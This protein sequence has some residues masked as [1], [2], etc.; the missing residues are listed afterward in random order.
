MIQKAL[1]DNDAATTDLRKALAIN[2]HFSILWSPVAAR[3]LAKLGRAAREEKEI[4]V[5][6]PLSRLVCV[7][8]DF[9]AAELAELLPLLASELNVKM[10]EFADS[11]SAL[12]TLVGKASFRSL[13]KQFG[14]RTPEA[15]KAVEALTS[16]QLLAFERG[17]TVSVTVDGEEY[18]LLPEDVTIVRHAAGSLLVRE[19]NG[20]FAAID[21]TI[22]P[23]LRREGA[24]R[25]LVSKIQQMRK[26]ARFAVSD[27]VRV[28]LEGGAELAAV[29]HEYGT[30]IAGEVL[31]NEITVAGVL[32]ETP[33][34]VQ[35]IV[36][37]A[38]TV[39]IALT[40][41]S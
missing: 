10:V 41:V 39:R 35:T 12:A 7:V 29:V 34:A 36:L 32:G 25:E 5:R 23:E 30:Y 6:Q 16:E 14:K 9:K 20:L 4:K 1:G 37:D 3:V 17:E 38:E 13:G 40:R 11:G 19:E 31:A 15:A 28:D 2:P 27:R 22:T 33:D 8:P 21:P 24:A 18:P 26:A